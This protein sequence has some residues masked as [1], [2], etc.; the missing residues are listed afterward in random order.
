[1]SDIRNLREIERLQSLLMI[2]N[3]WMTSMIDNV[4]TLKTAMKTILK[5]WIQLGE[6]TSD[7]YCHLS[8]PPRPQRQWGQ[9]ED[10]TERQNYISSFDHNPVAWS[11]VKGTS[12]L[13][14]T[15][16]SRSTC[17]TL[18]RLA[19]C[20]LHSFCAYLERNQNCAAISHNWGSNEKR[21]CWDH[22]WVDSPFLV[23]DLLHRNSV[24]KTDYWGGS[25]YDVSH[26]RSSPASRR[27]RCNRTRR[28]YTSRF[29][30]Q[31]WNKFE[32]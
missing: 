21:S 30:V 14:H 26:L 8:L 13:S 19:T 20:D 22:L 16:L 9:N 5:S 27:C 12:H 1:M 32:L 24:T 3:L 23:V 4:A 7:F 2:D 17:V 18:L 25:W 31:V 29:T 6:H 15:A 11:L 10:K 28:I